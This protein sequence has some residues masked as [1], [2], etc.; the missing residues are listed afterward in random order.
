M[1]LLSLEKVLS[2]TS[3]SLWAAATRFRIGDSLVWK[4]DTQKDSVL[5]V[6][7]EAYTACNTPS[8]IVAYKDGNTK[9]EL[10]WSGPFYF[11]NGTEENCQKGEKMTVVMLSPRHHGSSSS[12][13]APAPAV[14]QEGPALTVLCFLADQQGLQYLGCSGLLPQ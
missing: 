7:K 13:L 8:L 9:V 4:Y 12:D 14:A 1:N 6:T 3:L 10:A 2:P 11:I 5:Q